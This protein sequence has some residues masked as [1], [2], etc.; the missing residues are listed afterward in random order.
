M[1]MVLLRYCAKAELH[2]ALLATPQ[3]CLRR[4]VLMDKTSIPVSPLLL[5][6]PLR[7]AT[8]IKTILAELMLS[9]SSLRLPIDFL[10]DGESVA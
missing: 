8:R 10:S 7:L 4:G 6:A 2:R 1:K 9:K 5:F 3:G